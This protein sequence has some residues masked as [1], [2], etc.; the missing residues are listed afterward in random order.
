MRRMWTT[1]RASALAR[2]AVLVGLAGLLAAGC[3]SPPK[4]KATPIQDQ[5]LRKEPA[6]GLS[7]APPL[8]KPCPKLEPG[9]VLSK[10]QE[11][12]HLAAAHNG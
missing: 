3:S 5:A 10:Q 4:P 9:A 12:D 6:G 8:G 2:G 11:H 1:G 7:G